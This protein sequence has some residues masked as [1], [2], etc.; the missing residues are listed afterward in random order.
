MNISTRVPLAGNFPEQALMLARGL[1]ELGE[2]EA[3]E[4]FSVQMSDRLL[5]S[6]V[7]VCV[8]CLTAVEALVVERKNRVVMLRRCAEHQNP[9]TLLES[10]SAF[11]RISSNDRYGRVYARDILEE[12]PEYSSCSPRSSCC[13][14]SPDGKQVRDWRE[15]F[16]DQSSNKSCTVLVEITNAC[17]LACTVCYADSRGDRILGIERY[18]QYVAGL[19]ERKKILDSIQITGGEASMHPEFWE[20]LEWTCA[21]PGIERV[22]LPTNGIEFSK[23]DKLRRLKTYRHKLLVLL[24]LDGQE[25][26]TNQALRAANP[27]KPK[28]RLI[29]GLNRLKVPMQLT[30]TLAR[31]V[32][33][34]EIAWVVRQGVN[35]RNIR[36]V[37][38]LPAFFT[39]RY[40]IDG[41]PLERA[42][43]SDAVKGVAAGLPRKFRRD[44]FMPIPCSHP[45]CGWTSLFARRFGLMMN[46]SR[47]V[48]Q[49]SAKS[50]AAYTT[51]LQ[52]ASL[53]KLIGT[54]FGSFLSR[55][56]T[57]VGACLVR[58]RD[59]F[60][61]VVKP[62]M[63]RYTFDYDRVA[64]CCHH[65]LDTDGRLLSFCEYNVRKRDDDDWG[66]QQ[67]IG[68]IP[69]VVS[70]EAD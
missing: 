35:H 48:S 62:F 60:G 23:P 59:V 2:D 9:A 67:R 53:R 37:A 49:D 7:S 51:T 6:T 15:D 34:Q 33:D 47:F 18:K 12:W 63:D 14:S 56:G 28:L 1:R 8:H 17:N 3:R 29:Q 5:K 65:M 58:P 52:A 21:Q 27:L 32:S 61:V 45:N 19:L 4:R 10:D 36:L 30:M 31:G 13:D 54:R 39:G 64:N 26:S 44:D 55:I 24:Q 50:S 46:V 68:N 43:L 11:Y 38:I 69:V 42:T 20:I 66:R 70:G 22:Y 16:F 41:D 40:E 57:R 25:V